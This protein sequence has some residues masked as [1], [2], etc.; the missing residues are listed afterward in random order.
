MSSRGSY[1]VGWNGQDRRDIHTICTP[2][3]MTQLSCASRSYPDA[4]L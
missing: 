3:T 2:S 1:N 4:A